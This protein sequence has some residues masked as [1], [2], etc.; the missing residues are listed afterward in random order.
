MADQRPLGAH[1]EFYRR[2]GI[3]LLL[4]QL[5]TDANASIAVNGSLEL[6]QHVVHCFEVLEVWGEVV[7]DESDQLC[8]LV[9]DCEKLESYL[10]LRLAACFVDSHVEIQLLI[11]K[12]GLLDRDLLRLLVLRPSL[13]NGLN[14][15]Y[16]AFQ[17]GLH[18]LWRVV[19]V[20]LVCFW[21]LVYC[22]H[23]HPDALR[24]VYLHI[25]NSDRQ[26]G[27]RGTDH[28]V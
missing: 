28:Q 16:S 13:L 1:P 2:H 4:L 20:P 15:V 3:D 10:V 26:N 14:C 23:L 21:R 27:H 12:V 25:M 17:L 19:R 18:R 5:R 8:L 24:Y 9:V 6:Y 11:L 22:L 7:V